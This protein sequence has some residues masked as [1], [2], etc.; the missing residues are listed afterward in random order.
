[1][2][3]VLAG[4]ATS[5]GN[6]RHAQHARDQITMVQVQ[7]EA[8]VQEAQADAQTNTA[9]VEALAEVARANPDHAPAVTV[10]LCH[11]CTGSR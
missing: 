8:M 10:A 5:R 6:E 2:V 4:C 9:L 11:W 3:A 7:R 1:M